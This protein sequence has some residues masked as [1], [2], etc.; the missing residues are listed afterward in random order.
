ML[1]ADI[2]PFTLLEHASDRGIQLR[3]SIEPDA[4]VIGYL[5]GSVGILQGRPWVSDD[6]V[7]LKG[8]QLDLST[9]SNSDIV[10][11][12]LNLRLANESQRAV[13]DRV[14]NGEAFF[15]STQ[16]EAFANLCE[17]VAEV[18]GTSQTSP[19]PTG[20]SSEI[21]AGLTARLAAALEPDSKKSVDGER[22]SLSL[23]RRVERFM[24]QNVEE[25]L[26]LDRIC[27]EMG[28]RM[29]SLIYSFK[30]SFGVGPMTYLKI[31]RLN[32]ARRKLKATRGQVRIFD[33]AA[34]FG[35][36]HMGHF[37]ADYKRMFGT[38]AS[39]TVSYNPYSG[40]RRRK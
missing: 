6:F 1:C 13:F 21:E 17:Y 26:T 12:Q 30:D 4:V 10:W 27:E 34:D 35:F 25:P 22:R 5:N 18:F 36:W 8:A 7:I 38:T 3:W 29:R 32:A 33:V 24:W 9:L 15:V 31:R 28:C 39:E 40:R 14:P 37:S 11:L 2:G 16:T 23:V 19:V 20:T